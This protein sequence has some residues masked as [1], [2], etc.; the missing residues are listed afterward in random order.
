MTWAEGPVR[1]APTRAHARP[2]A[3]VAARPIVVALAFRQPAVVQMLIKY[4]AAVPDRWTPGK[5][6]V[7]LLRWA[8]GL[9]RFR[10][11]WP[12]VWSLAKEERHALWL[13][14]CAPSNAPRSIAGSADEAFTQ[15]RAAYQGFIT[16]PASLTLTT[17][18]EALAAVRILDARGVWQAHQLLLLALRLDLFGSY[19]Y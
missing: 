2:R 13:A 17:L 7:G 15:L 16:T 5:L 9:E 6:G 11:S 14:A 8:I 18:A 19:P 3:R 10:R 4:G 12:Q 1:G